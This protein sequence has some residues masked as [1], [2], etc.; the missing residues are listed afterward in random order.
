MFIDCLRINSVDD[1][2]Q[3]NILH[4]FALDITVCRNVRGFNCTVSPRKQFYGLEFCII[5][6]LF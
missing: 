4:T 5:C 1:C 3:V 6:C 2:S